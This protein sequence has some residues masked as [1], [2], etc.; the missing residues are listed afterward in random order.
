MPA[1]LANKRIFD[2]MYS[3][4][5]AVKRLMTHLKE[6]SMTYY[7][8]EKNPERRDKALELRYIPIRITNTCASVV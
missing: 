4:H 8:E 6:K 5:A 7:L 2:G 1:A 3:V